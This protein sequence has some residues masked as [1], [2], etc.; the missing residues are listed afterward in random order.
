MAKSNENENKNDSYF[1]SKSVV[2][3]KTAYDRKMDVD[4]LNSTDSPND[5]GIENMEVELN[6]DEKR[7]S[8]KRQRDSSTSFEAKPD[9]KQ[10][11]IENAQSLSSEIFSLISK[12]FAVNFTVNGTS[13]SGGSEAIIVFPAEHFDPT[14]DYKNT[15][16]FI[17]MNVVSSLQDYSSDYDTCLQCFN[18]HKPNNF[19]SII[20]NQL[21]TFSIKPIEEDNE[22][23][24]LFYRDRSVLALSYLLDSYSRIFTEERHAPEK[25]CE[26]ATF[27][28]LITSIRNNCISFGILVLQNSKKEDKLNKFILR[29][30]YNGSL[31]CGFMSGLIAMTY[32]RTPEEFRK[33]FEPLLQLLWLDMQTYCSLIHDYMVKM[34]LLAL[35]ELCNV[36]VGKNNFP[37]GEL[38]KILAAPSYCFYTNLFVFHNRL[39]NLTHGYLSQWQ[40]QREESFRKFLTWHPFCVYR[41]SQRM[42]LV[43]NLF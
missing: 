11:N 8:L 2:K 39:H 40:I 28:E 23:T 35:V 4:N 36:A 42:T 14:D 21:S 9:S 17:I 43:F 41:F 30:M 3:E 38:V 29:L 10:N 34:P 7:E 31:P 25:W 16:Q 13:Y 37:I 15:V 12:I 19:T 22:G 1:E 20:S 24:F 5:S 27:A 18:E 26:V 33:I 6:I 32:Q